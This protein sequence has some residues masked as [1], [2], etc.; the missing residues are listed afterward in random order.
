MLGMDISPNTIFISNR[1]RDPDEVDPEG[2]KRRLCSIWKRNPDGRYLEK[3]QAPVDYRTPN[4]LVWGH[5]IDEL[6]LIERDPGLPIFTQY[7]RSQLKELGENYDDVEWDNTPLVRPRVKRAWPVLKLPKRHPANTFPPVGA[8]DGGCDEEHDKDCTYTIRWDEF[9]DDRRGKTTPRAGQPPPACSTD[10]ANPCTG[11]WLPNNPDGSGERLQNPAGHVYDYVWCEHFAVCAQ[12][13]GDPFA[14]LGQKTHLMIWEP[15]IF[16]DFTGVLRFDAFRAWH[17]FLPP[18]ALEAMPADHRATAGVRAGDS[19]AAHPKVS[20]LYAFKGLPFSFSVT[21]LDPEDEESYDQARENG[22]PVEEVDGKGK[23]TDAPGLFCLKGLPRLEE[24]I[25]EGLFPDILLVHDPAELTNHTQLGSEPVKYKRLFPALARDVSKGIKGLPTTQNV[26][27]LHL[28]KRNRLGTGHHSYVYRAP[29]T[30]PPPLSARS[31]TGQCTVAAKLAFP[32][33]TAHALLANEGKVYSELPRHTQEEYCGFNIVP[34]CNYPVPVGAIVPKF[35]GYY[36]PM[37]EDGEAMKGYNEE[38]GV[39]RWCDE[40]GECEVEWTSPILLMEECGTPVK[41]A[42][43]SADERTECFSLLHR[44]HKLNILQGSPY[45]RNVLVQPGPLTDPLERRSL[46]TPSFRVVDFGR[47]EVYT[48][49]ADMTREE[50]ERARDGFAVR[51]RD[52]QK[53]AREEMLLE[54]PCG[55]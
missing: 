20:G 24:F 23:T 7:S 10:P 19:E 45:V 27:H 43:F 51:I 8:I 17:K 12:E 3:N 26:A 28:H 53:G 32:H 9:S 4:D 38:R 41:P 47:G 39:H 21:D 35:Y 31:H 29:L 11:C 54:Y 50:R 42:K 34:P 1:G 22:F 49:R 46:D 52:E 6:C 33:C 44:L 15:R 48:E 2:R 5:T 25:P 16:A 55:F 14:F 40:S 37:G 18:G 36:V 13:S 30:L